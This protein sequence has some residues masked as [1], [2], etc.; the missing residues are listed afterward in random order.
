VAGHPKQ[1]WPPGLKI[2][3]AGTALAAVP[4]PPLFSVSSIRWFVMHL[5]LPKGMCSMGK[6]NNSQK[7]DKKNKKP[8][9]DKT[10]TPV[11]K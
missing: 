7:N 5:N 4:R 2:P 9:Q 3:Q 11:K 1:F 10:K 8:K 6:G